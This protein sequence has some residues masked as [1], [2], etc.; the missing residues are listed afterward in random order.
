M[1]QDNSW[2]IFFVV[3]VVGFYCNIQ[4]WALKAHFTH[5]LS[6]TTYHPK[7][8]L[9]LVFRMALRKMILSGL[10]DNNHAIYRL[11]SLELHQ[12]SILPVLFSFH[13]YSIFQE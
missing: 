4:E 9:A 8:S 2:G 6:P 11:H 12:N 1:P 5:H 3:I 10:L 7:L 13:I